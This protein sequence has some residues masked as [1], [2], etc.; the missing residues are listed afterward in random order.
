MSKI[1]PEEY[2]VTV[3]TWSPITVDGQNH[4]F[5]AVRPIQSFADLGE[6]LVF[7][8]D[9][10]EQWDSEE[11]DGHTLLLIENTEEAGDVILGAFF[12]R[13]GESQ[14]VFPQPPQ[15][16]STAEDE[17][18][19]WADPYIVS[20]WVDVLGLPLTSLSASVSNYEGIDFDRAIGGGHPPM[21]PVLLPGAEI[22]TM[23]GVRPPWSQTLETFLA[24]LEAQEE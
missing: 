8:F 13:L 6:L 11:G 22:Y 9:D 10:Q 3:A 20:I 4:R 7:W 17:P 15:R 5:R 18:E 12:S 24:W 23:L 16:V 21:H 19:I 14:S 2:A 1:I